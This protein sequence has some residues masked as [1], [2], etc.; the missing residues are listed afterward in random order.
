MYFS[1]FKLVKLEG[2]EYQVS[3]IVHGCSDVVTW[4][5]ERN[6]IQG[7]IAIKNFRMIPMSTEI[8]RNAYRSA[9]YQRLLK[10]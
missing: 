9:M 10:R 8:R 6:V 1:F 4:L 7:L 2:V 5:V 3:A